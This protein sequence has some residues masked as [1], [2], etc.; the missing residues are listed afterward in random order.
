LVTG[1][2][3]KQKTLLLLYRSA[4]NYEFTEDLYSWVEYSSLSMFKTAILKRLHEKKFIEYDRG[5]DIV[6]LSPLGIVEVE[7]NILAK[8]IK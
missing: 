6:H 3:F 2:D 8:I 4:E 5:T 7:N 1:L